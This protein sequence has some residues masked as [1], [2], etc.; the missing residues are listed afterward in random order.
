LPRVICMFLCT[1]LLCNLMKLVV[2][3]NR[4]R[5]FDLSQHVYDSFAG[6][7][8]LA[9]AG[10][11]GQSMPSAHTASAVALAVGLCWLY[12]RGKYLWITLAT[13][14]SMQ[15]IDSLAHFPSD[16]V[17]GTAFGLLIGLGI[18]HGWLSNPWLDRLEG[19]LYRRRA[20]GDEASATMNI[21]QSDVAKYRV[22]RL[23]SKHKAVRS[24]T[25]DIDK[26]EAA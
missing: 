5:A 25:S 15:R 10:S 3:R 6:F 21:L 20:N 2:E 9:S 26:Q 14:A 11:G 19:H 16:V 8:P 23:R 18:L 12:P 1:G 22:D 24:S 17:W 7:L 4:P 13:L